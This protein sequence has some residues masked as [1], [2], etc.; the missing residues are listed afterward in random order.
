[1]NKIDLLARVVALGVVALSASVG[2]SGA[3]PL[4]GDRKVQDDG[5]AAGGENEKDAGTE[6][7][8]PSVST[9]VGKL[10]V[11]I[12]DTQQVFFTTATARNPKANVPARMANEKRVF[13]LAAA[14]KVPTFVSYEAS[15]SGDHALPP[16]LAAV[17][18]P[19]AQEFIKTTFAATGQPQFLGAI[20]ASE[21]R[22]LLV[23]GA[24]TDV[25]VLQSMLGLRRAG[26]EVLA[27]VDALFT[28]EVNDGPAL[29][30]MR[31]AGIVAVTMQDAEALI[32]NGA[33]SPAA[34][35]SGPPLIVSPLE[36]GIVL[37]DLAGLSVAD[38]NAAAKKARMKE[39]LLISEWFK[40]PVLA[41]DPQA[42]LAALPADL[43]AIVKR[44]FLALSAR[45]AQVKQLVV[46]G[47]RSGL[48]AVVTEL[49]KGGDVFLVEDALFGGASADLE[50]LYV[51]GA[52]PTTYKTLYYEMI[53]SVNDAQWPSQQWVTDSNPYFDLT[54]SPEELPPLVP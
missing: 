52:V 46:A 13:E 53:Q 39:L 22:R 44:P 45:P 50:P 24:E 37:H 11:V 1:M 54:K 12:I 8:D 19:Q 16:S 7:T 27:L 32:T 28:E 17:L 41:A 18:P 6:T 49:Q 35:A 15:K 43:K 30:R 2:C 14:S 23:V 51:K 31:Q 33:A 25:C 10:A 5:T 29:R 21:A 34:P 40:M 36:T 47:G 26:F 20:K 3:T 48:D 4:S 42:A 9:S 38:P